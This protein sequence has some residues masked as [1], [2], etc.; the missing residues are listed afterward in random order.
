MSWLYGND[1][2]VEVSTG[3]SLLVVLIIISDV[4]LFC[5]LFNFDSLLC[6]VVDNSVSF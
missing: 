3:D 2:I 5:L 6:Q 1:T 4:R